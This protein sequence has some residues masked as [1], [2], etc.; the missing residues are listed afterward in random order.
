MMW[1]S[2]AA[3]RA[4]DAA[5]AALTFVAVA[6]PMITNHPSPGDRRVDAFAWLL[7]VTLAALMFVRRRWPVEV[8]LVSGGLLLGYYMLRYPPVGLELPMAAAFYTVAEAG[9]VWWGIGYGLLMQVIGL[10]ARITQGQDPQ[11]LLAFELPPAL[12]ITAGALA[13]GDATR[14]RRL[15]RAEQARVEA[16]AALEHELE[17][18]RRVEQERV[19]LAREL[20]DVLA[21]SVS[22]MGIHSGVAAEALEDDDKAAAARAVASVRRTA[23]EAMR[24]LR[25]TLGILRGQSTGRE[26]WGRQVSASTGRAP[27]GSLEHLEALATR[28]EPQVST[29]A[30]PFPT[31]RASFRAPSPRPPTGS[32]RRLSPTCS[33]TPERR[34]PS[35]RWRWPMAISTC[36]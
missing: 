31:M 16:A 6:I 12:A 21:H 27:V 15:Q 30:W 4:T 25:A 10:G 20:H 26:E 33:G 29:S 24:D 2:K 22:V 1:G 11:L 28:P 3:G 13:L 7:P 36:G 17:A 19:R 32:C 8:M 35:S 18:E 23:R 34:A 9:R 5:L 14:Q